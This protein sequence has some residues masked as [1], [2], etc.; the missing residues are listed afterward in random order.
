MAEIKLANQDTLGEEEQD[1]P[2]RYQFY[3]S[4]YCHL[5]KRVLAEGQTNLQDTEVRN[6][7]TTKVATGKDSL[8]NKQYEDNH[9]CTFLKTLGTHLTLYALH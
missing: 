2:K 4:S 3:Y 8:V 6:I 9:L 7:R 5:G 1:C